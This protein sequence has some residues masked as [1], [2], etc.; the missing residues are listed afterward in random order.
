MSTN[1]VGDEGASKLAAKLAA[2]ALLLTLDLSS[3]GIGDR[4]AAALAEALQL[5]TTLQNLDLRCA[6]LLL[7]HMLC[8]CMGIWVCRGLE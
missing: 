8:L 2:N 5:N 1:S 7:L 6:Q 4:G 3:N